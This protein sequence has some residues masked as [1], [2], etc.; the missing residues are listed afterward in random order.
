MVLPKLFNVVKN[1]EEAAEPETSAESGGT[2]LDN[3]VENIEQY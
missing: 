1:S 2:M 3:I